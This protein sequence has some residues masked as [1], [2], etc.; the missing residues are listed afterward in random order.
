MTGA[1]PRTGYRPDI[2]GLRAFAVIAVIVNHF[3]ASLLPSGFLGVDI[4]FV[5]SGYVITLSLSGSLRKSLGSFLAHFYK[6]RLLRLLPALLVMVTVVSFAFSIICEAPQVS[7]KTAVA[8]LFGASNFYL[9]S[10]SQNYFSE[11]SELNPFTHTWSLGVEEQFYA[12]FPFIFW[13]FNRSNNR[14]SQSA[15]ISNAFIFFLSLVSIFSLMFFFSS[16]L[17]GSE[18]VYFLPFGRVWELAAGSLV[19][20][21]SSRFHGLFVYLKTCQLSSAC[22][23]CTVF[24]CLLPVAQSNYA[25]VL[26]VVCA[27]FL[28]A[29]TGQYCLAT[30]FLS[31]RLIVG[32]GLMSYS[33]YLWHWPILSISRWTTGIHSWFVPM[34]VILILAFSFLSYF[35]IELPVRNAFS[36]AASGVIYRIGF[37]AIF[38]ASSFIIVLGFQLRKSLFVEGVRRPGKAYSEELLWDIKRCLNYQAQ[39]PS[40]ELLDHCWLRE[41]SR[42]TANSPRTLLNSGESRQVFA[43]GNS[44]NEQLL[45]AYLLLIGKQLPIR[46]HAYAEGGCYT[47]T[48]LATVSQDKDCNSFL[49]SYYRWFDK[50]S[51]RGD[52]LVVATSYMQFFPTI[53][54][55]NFLYRGQPVNAPEALSIYIKELNQ[56][57]RRLKVNGRSL[58]VISGIPLLAQPLDVCYSRLALFNDKCKRVLNDEANLVLERF[59]KKDLP[60]RLSKDIIYVNIY[61]SLHSGIYLKTISP[62]R[63]YMNESHVSRYGAFYVANQIASGVN[64]ALG[65]SH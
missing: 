45:P 39:L 9:Y 15:D 17:I 65:F 60:A 46:L 21:L 54:P 4:F 6:R 49:S 64:Y 8:S 16:S 14:P 40:G 2:D 27:A 56:L 63:I 33:L 24:L 22:L 7:L 44:Y 37:I 3:N 19:Y 43:I 36:Q 10:Q 11:A 48:V 53:D 12:F 34:Q 59:Y 13:I 30:K 35:L 62:Y 18:A 23:I 47:S 29:P 20:S 28:V 38:L 58:V 1:I 31:S 25:T 5:I 51:R 41:P 57:S 52:V 32:I 42:K 55:K 61:D 26:V 50:V